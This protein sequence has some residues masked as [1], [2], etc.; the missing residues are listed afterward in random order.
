M[1]PI[2]KDNDTW[3]EMADLIF[4]KASELLSSEKKWTKGCDARNDKGVMVDPAG[5]DAVCWCLNGAI[6][7]A[8][9]EIYPSHGSS[10]LH[11]VKKCRVRVIELTHHL[12]TQSFNDCDS[13]TYPDVLDVLARGSNY[14]SRYE[15][16][17]GEKL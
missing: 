17:T 5:D 15:S 12:S 1:T 11:I 10:L 14:R 9:K 16:R 7:R 4:T 3:T 8:A 6:V 13:T 2:L